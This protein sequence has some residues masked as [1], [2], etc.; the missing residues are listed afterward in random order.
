MTHSTA[1]TAH[2]VIIPSQN[3]HL[4]G[5]LHIPEAARGIVLFAHGSGSSRFSKRNQFVASVLNAANFATLLFDLF[6]LEEEMQ[7][8][9]KREL[10]FDIEFLASRLVDATEWCATQLA[11]QDLS[12]GYFGASTGGGAAIVAAAKESRIVKTI[13]SRGGRPDLAGA[14]LPLVKAPT[15]FIVGGDDE[16]VIELNRSA[17]A[18]MQ[19]VKQLDIVPGATHLFEEPDTL[20]AVASLAT[21]WFSQ[22]LR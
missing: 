7:D 9:D 17:M 22:Y 5:I 2:S 13:V 1:N 20:E 12:I 10:V 21:A 18:K 19:C 8:K 15:L 16:P 6:T 11:T 4:D 3:V 14:A